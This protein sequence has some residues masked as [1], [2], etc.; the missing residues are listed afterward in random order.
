MTNKDIGKVIRDIR[1]SRGITATF[2]SRKLGYQSVS[3][4]TRLESG[5]S[6]I[7]LET[8]KKIAEL[9]S[10][11]LDDFF[12]NEKLRELHNEKVV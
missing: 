7:S 1:T 9:L 5:E 10:V 12:C 11:N 8:A 3:S 2:I 6:I 4:Y